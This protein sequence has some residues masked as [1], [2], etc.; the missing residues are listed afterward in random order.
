MEI[1]IVTSGIHIGWYEAVTRIA[2]DAAGF[3]VDWG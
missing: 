1:R 2:I 3:L